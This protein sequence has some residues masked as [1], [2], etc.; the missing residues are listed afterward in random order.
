MNNRKPSRTDVKSDLRGVDFQSIETIR[1]AVV[2][3]TESVCAKWVGYF[4]SL[5][6]IGPWA[7]EIAKSE[8]KYKRACVW[9]KP[10]STPQL[11]GEGPAQGAEAFFVGWNGKGNARWNAGGKRGVYTHGVQYRAR[12]GGHPTEKPISLMKEIL[13]DFTKP[14]ESILDPFMGSGTTGVACVQL[15]RPFIGIEVDETY[16]DIACE[17]IERASG[18]PSLFTAEK[19]K[20]P[21]NQDLFKDRAAF[22]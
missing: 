15:G 9:V 18:Q 14:G 22:G 5:E 19:T 12:Y 2:A 13:L 17:R 10:D 16:F 21:K 1:P 11:N 8:I 4:C 3:A 7:A 20:P 6:G